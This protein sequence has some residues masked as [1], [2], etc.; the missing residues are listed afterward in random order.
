MSTDKKKHIS[1]REFVTAAGAAA[2]GGLVLGGAA[3]YLGGS[4]GD[5]SGGGPDGDKS[6][7]TIGLG[8]PVTGDLASDGEVMRN[9]LQLGVDQINDN[10][11]VLGRELKV[12]VVDTK[13]QSPN[14]LTST[15]RKFV[16]D[17][18][19]AIFLPQTT[20]TSVEY[21]VVADAGV[22]MFHFN[23]FQGNLDYVRDNKISNIFMGTPPE[24]WYGSGF[25]RFVNDELIAKK[26]WKPSS[27]S[28]SVITSND[29]Y[30]LNIAKAFRSYM[31]DDGWDIKMFEE[32]TAPQADWGPMLT[33]IRQDAPGVIFFSDY[34]VGDEV[35]F[36]K[37]FAENP[38]ES[39]VYQLYAPS[40]PEYL[41]LAGD[42]ANGV[43]WS[44]VTGTISTDEIGRQFIDDY[45]ARFDSDPG[46]S[47][48]GIQYDLVR[49]WARSATVAGDPGDYDAVCAEVGRTIFRGVSGSFRFTPDEHA[50]LPYPDA[51]NDPS[52]AVPHLTFQVRDG[53]H[54]MVSPSPFAD[55]EFELP[56]WLT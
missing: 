2:A 19:A 4:S 29:P 47:T 36:M 10:G 44:T 48:A 31:E 28:A 21:K 38:T 43:I 54:K 17:G 33:K 6:P 45:R 49:L 27:K 22:P 41:N 14:D 15:T 24:K 52:L 53:E 40:V 34:L 18:V 42:A 13:G 9:G 23:T 3:G 5:E 39:L 12:S 16:S 1:R 37:Q 55:S 50:V 56:S 11:G 25:G 8:V 26:L 32:F 7:I 51:V 35:S 20:Y 30:S 46:M